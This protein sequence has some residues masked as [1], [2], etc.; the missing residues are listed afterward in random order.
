MRDQAVFKNVRGGGICSERAVPFKMAKKACI[1]DCI[2]T[3]SVTD[4]ETTWDEAEDQL[5]TYLQTG[6]VGVAV[7]ASHASFQNY[8]GGVY[9]GNCNP[10]NENVNVCVHC[11]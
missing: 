10:A 8:G 1:Q 9:D 3:A 6:A 4:V 11:D 7:Y 2:P 5:A